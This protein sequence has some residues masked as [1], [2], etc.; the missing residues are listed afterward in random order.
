MTAQ[1]IQKYREAC[2]RLDDSVERVK[3][4][5]KPI[6]FAGIIRDLIKA[7][8]DVWTVYEAMDFSQK[9]QGYQDNL[10]GEKP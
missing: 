3:N 8:W 6:E 1:Q 2:R 7:A 10:L 5:P 9:N 4:C